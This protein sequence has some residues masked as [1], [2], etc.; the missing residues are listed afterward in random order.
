MFERAMGRAEADAL[1]SRHN[2]RGCQLRRPYIPPKKTQA[3]VSPKSAVERITDS[4]RTSCDVRKVPLP[5]VS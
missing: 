2:E 5:E 4:S 1:R 3:A